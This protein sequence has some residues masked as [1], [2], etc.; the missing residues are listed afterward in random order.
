MRAKKSLGQNFL[1]SKNIV[2]DIIHASQIKS[3]DIIL[4]VGPGKGT[5]N[6]HESTLIKIVGDFWD[7]WEW[8]IIDLWLDIYIDIM[9]GYSSGVRC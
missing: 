1:K 3:N 8:R 7:G 5:T 9:D 6:E 2:N 4:E